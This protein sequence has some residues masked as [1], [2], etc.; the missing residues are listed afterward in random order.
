VCWSTLKYLGVPLV[1]FNFSIGHFALVSKVFQIVS[2]ALI[3]KS[4]QII[5]IVVHLGKFEWCHYGYCNHTQSL[6][7][8]HQRLLQQAG[9]WQA[10]SLKRQSWRA[11]Y[12]CP[13]K[14]AT[15]SKIQRSDGFSPQAI[16]RGRKGCYSSTRTAPAIWRW[17]LS[18]GSSIRTSPAIPRE[19]SGCD[20]STRT[21]PAS[22]MK[23][24]IKLWQYVVS[25]RAQLS[26]ENKVA[27]TAVPGRASP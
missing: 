21:A 17:I 20:S 2:V 3:S 14:F 8:P 7:R 5:P 22:Y 11:S 4:E 23:M 26:Q 9:M 15:D 24:N 6:N 25:G 19:E 10:W 13:T 12:S 27:V 16:S 1:F 18:C